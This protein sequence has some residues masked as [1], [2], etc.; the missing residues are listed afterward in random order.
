MRSFSRG[1]CPGWLSGTFI[2]SLQTFLHK[3]PQ[4]RFE[5]LSALLAYCLL[6]TAYCLLLT[7]YCLLLLSSK[8]LGNPN[9][10]ALQHAIGNFDDISAIGDCAIFKIAA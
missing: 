4:T 7:A 2:S 8:F 3:V 9:V 10:I 1:I 5:A 6:L